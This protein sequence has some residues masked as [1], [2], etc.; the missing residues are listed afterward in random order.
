MSWQ[1]QAITTG[2]RLLLKRPLRPGESVASIRRRFERGAR[3]MSA[4][5]KGWD[6]EIIASGPLRGEWIRPQ[7]HKSPRPGAIF[8]IHGGGYIFCTAE[9]HRPLVTALAEK[10]GMPAFSIEY[11]R[12]P[13]HPFPAAMDDC[14]AAY[15][16]LLAS[17]IPA[18][19]IFISGDSAGAGLALATALQARE[20]NVP[21]PGGLFLLSPWVD[22]AATG[23]SYRENSQSDAMFYGNSIRP[24]AELYLQGTSPTNPLAS[25]LY[26]DL[27]GMSPICIHASDSELFR[28]DAI[29]L[30]ENATIYHVS[31]SLQIWHGMPHDWQ[32]FPKFI[33]EAN[34]SLIAGAR[35][36]SELLDPSD[37]GHQVT[38]KL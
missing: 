7:P 27:T 5:P 30:A 9:T 37:E 34:E 20:Q 36:I 2:E 15:Q 23:A 38:E 29:K 3:F 13:E 4:L 22:L 11:R 10:A 18:R 32:L 26:A 24:A 25:P 14:F 28:D 1:S 6:R 17:G 21:Q 8:F 16:A 35:F 19:H 12:A 33:P 31:V